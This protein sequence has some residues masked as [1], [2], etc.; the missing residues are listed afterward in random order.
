MLIPSRPEWERQSWLKWIAGGE[1]EDFEVMPGSE[2]APGG[3]D[4]GGQ[5][6]KDAG[7]GGRDAEGLADFLSLIARLGTQVMYL[8][9]Y[10]CLDSRTDTKTLIHHNYR[11]RR[12]KKMSFAFSLT[13]RLW[14]SLTRFTR[15]KLWYIFSLSK[16]GEINWRTCSVTKVRRKNL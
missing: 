7:Q 5:G 1:K 16:F 9:L 11:A 10:L 13:P 2:M 8:Y 14:L 12:S 6:G 4:A 15:E 3:K